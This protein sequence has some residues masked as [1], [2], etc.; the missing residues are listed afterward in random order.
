MADNEVKLTLKPE[1]AGLIASIKEIK[2]SFEGVGSAISS[3]VGLAIDAV[4][5]IKQLE[6]EVRQMRQDFEQAAVSITKASSSLA[7]ENLKLQDQIA[8]LEHRPARNQLA[9]ALV[10]A[11]GRARELTSSLFDAINK[12][13]DLLENKSVN[14]VRSLAS[15][16][17][18]TND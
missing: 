8:V 9:I 18:M 6:Q 14:F 12:E 1:D 2:T 4:E 17:A 5:K 16:Q 7:D 3:V 10:E 11:A 15:G 13:R